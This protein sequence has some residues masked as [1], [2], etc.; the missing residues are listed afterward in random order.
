MK[1]IMTSHRSMCS[2]FQIFTQPSIQCFI[3]FVWSTIS[4]G[5]D[6][7][8]VE[9]RKYTD[10]MPK[11]IRRKHDKI[12]VKLWLCAAFKLI[13]GDFWMICLPRYKLLHW[14]LIENELLTLKRRLVP[15]A[16]EQ[17][18][19]YLITEIWQKNFRAIVSLDKY[20]GI[21]VKG[22]KNRKE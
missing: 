14:T 22:D 6:Y 15:S 13:V 7:G 17:N 20:S 11:C 3:D 18:A 16:Q 2:Q 9:I 19:H 1:I 21:R 4:I 8:H 10:V 5:N 12:Q